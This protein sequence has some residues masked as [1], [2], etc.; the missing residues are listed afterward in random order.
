[1]TKGDGK[2]ATF[3]TLVDMA[4]QIA[5]GMTYLESQGYVHRQI[6]ASNVLVGENNFCKIGDFIMAQ[7][8]VDGEYVAHDGAKYPIKWT[9]LEAALYST[10]TVKSDVWSFGILL[11]ELVGHI[12]YPGMTSAET[13]AQ[14]ERGYRM[15]MPPKC[16]KSL[17][18]IM[19]KCWD[20]DPIKRPTFE[21]LHDIL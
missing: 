13:L 18:E 1:M 3:P 21:Y 9:A 11:V 12:P 16:T 17:Y 6:M 5:S 7:M 10:F 19:L 2:N 15:P 20:K 8:L 14:V 4:A